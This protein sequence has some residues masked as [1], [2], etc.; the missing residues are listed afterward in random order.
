MSDQAILTR[1]ANVAK[2]EAMLT[3]MQASTASQRRDISQPLLR[4]AKEQKVHE[5]AVI[6][7]LKQGL[8]DL[9]A[10]PDG[11]TLGTNPVVVDFTW[12]ELEARFRQA[13]LTESNPGRPCLAKS[14]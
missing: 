5:L 4:Q 2:I 3:N 6:A 13:G 8:R 1:K 10:K 14:L 9:L 7:E 11:A 12:K